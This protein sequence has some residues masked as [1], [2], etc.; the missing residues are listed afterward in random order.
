M[1][2]HEADALAFFKS[3]SELL[4]H[5]SI[6]GENKK[7]T[8][9]INREVSEELHRDFSNISQLAAGAASEF[10]Q[11]DERTMLRESTCWLS[12]P[13]PSSSSSLSS[14]SRLLFDESLEDRRLPPQI[15][16]HLAEC[17][18]PMPTYGKLVHAL[19]MHVMLPADIIHTAVVKLELSI[20]KQEELRE[21]RRPSI[22]SKRPRQ[23]P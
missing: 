18:H 21:K 15:P 14:A 23:K 22:A 13:P 3:C 8:T 7:G 9:S 16:S 6:V 5:P 4:F 17:V 1:G 19:A 10:V 12:L 20:H 2:M 11:D